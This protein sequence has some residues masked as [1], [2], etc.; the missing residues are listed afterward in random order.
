M[1][2][3]AVVIVLLA[4][5]LA[6]PVPAPAQERA[7]NEDTTTS[8][9][10]STRRIRE[11]LE[12][13]GDLPSA[14]RP[15]GDPS[16]ERQASAVALLAANERLEAARLALGPEHPSLAPL[17]ID[18]SLCFVNLGWSVPASEYYALALSLGGWDQVSRHPAVPEIL[19]KLFRL[20]VLS[21]DWPLAAARA[22]ELLR[23]H[24][25]T[26]GPDH[27]DTWF[28]KHQIGAEYF[29]AGNIAE[30][31]THLE[32][33]IPTLLRLLPPNDARRMSVLNYKGAL[34]WERSDYPVAVDAFRGAVAAA[35]ASGH[36]ADPNLAP[37]LSNLGNALL[38]TGHPLEAAAAFTRC[39]AH[40]DSVAPGYFGAKSRCWLGV[41]SAYRAQG[42]DKAA[43]KSFK[44]HL[45]WLK[46]GRYGY[47][48][49]CIPV[50]E[51]Y[52]TM[53]R[54]TGRGS[55]AADV[56]SRIAWWKANEDAAEP[57]I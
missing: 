39:V 25:Q 16:P 31:T 44:E 29:K 40:Y 1:V 56:E 9:F 54:E 7:A 48:G 57:C 18:M 11:E 24:Y 35:E 53:L 46:A 45:N 43:E 52:A 3:S 50:L 51:P 38:M 6:H 14:L 21:K 13:W 33:T 12:L 4:V 42:M 37:M 20:S 47:S 23:V 36:G 8:E 26:L 15:G 5:G 10:P 2:R 28:Q 22:D 41:S 30:A 32:R 49:T 17:A 34:A 27:V 55:E 19:M